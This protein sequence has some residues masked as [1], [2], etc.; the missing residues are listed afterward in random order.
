M[1]FIYYKKCSTCLN[2]KKFLDT[3]NIKYASRDIKEENPT[4]E[5]IYSWLDKYNLDVNKLF[6]T[7]GLIYRELNLKDKMKTMSLDEKVSL[8]S[9][10]GMLVKRP[11]L[12]MD[13]NILIGFKETDYSKN[14]CK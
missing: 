4:K 2:A 3:H 12:I 1:L 10:N 14:L 13:D 7:S 6:N 5:E 8:L 11:L 9:Q